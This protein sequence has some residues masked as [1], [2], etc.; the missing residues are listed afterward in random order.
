MRGE[1]VTEIFVSDSMDTRSSLS[2]ATASHRHGWQQ[3]PACIEVNIWTYDV[4]KVLNE[5]NS[6]YGNVHHMEMNR[7]ENPANV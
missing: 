6:S 1:L 4:A 2:D 7:N 5:N 3:T